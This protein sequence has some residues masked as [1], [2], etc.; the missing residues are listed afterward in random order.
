MLALVGVLFAVY[1]LLDLSIGMSTDFS[2]LLMAVIQQGFIFVRS[3]SKVL[4]F[5]GEV[6]LF[7]S[8]QSII[9]QSGTVAGSGIVTEG[10]G[11]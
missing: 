5:G 10:S 3:W 11:A 9:F 6:S 1:F 7:E 2:I 8:Q 4:F